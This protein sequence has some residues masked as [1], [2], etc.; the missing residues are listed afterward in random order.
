MND[1][2]IPRRYAKALYKFALEKGESEHVYELM[3]R[4][5]ESFSA[6]PSLQ[7]VLGNPYVD[8]A[9]KCALLCT[10]SGATDADAVFNDFLKLL[11]ENRRIAFARE[12]ALAY[13]SI[14]RE[15]NAIY[16]VTVES[17]APLDKNE[18]GRIR[19]LVEKHLGGGK[20]EFN[21][22]VN[23]ELIGGFVVSVGNDRID[24]SISNELKQLRLN[25]LS[26]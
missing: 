25:L 23:P 6:E 4:L 13:V 24:A 26:K 19:A 3:R 20:L 21:T 2:L 7:S 18:E 1:G 5:A 9:D 16:M 12:I 11:V 10:A 15:E 17:A 8:D 22:S 14:F